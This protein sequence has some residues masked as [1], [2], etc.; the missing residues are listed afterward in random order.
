MEGAVMSKES[1]LPFTLEEHRQRLT[2]TR[3][4]VTRRG[5]DLMLVSIPENIF[6]LT[7]YD[8][9]GYF[10][11]QLIGVPRDG[12]PFMFMREI[13]ADHVLD[14]GIIGDVT[15]YSDRDD[16]VVVLRDTLAKR[17]FTS[18]AI[19]VEKDAWFFPP[20]RAERMQQAFAT[21]G[22]R[23]AAGVVEGQ[24][25]LK[26][27]A[28]IAYIRRA[29]QIA[30][31]GVRGGIAAVKA[32]VGEGEVAAAIYGALLR[33]GSEYAGPVYVMSGEQSALA[34]A[35]WSPRKLRQGDVVYIEVAGCVRRYHAAIRRTVTLGAAKPEVAK[36]HAACV[37]AQ[38]RMLP[39]LRP[40]VLSEEINRAHDEALAAA[41][42]S[43]YIRMRTAYSIGVSYPPGWGE[44]HI[45]DVRPGDRRPIQSR[46]SLHLGSQIIFRKQFGV[47]LSDTVIVREDGPEILTRLEQTLQEL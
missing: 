46:L 40:G 16:P 19:G 21:T 22:L 11:F 18:K 17:G 28:E 7:G 32:G 9:L 25:M 39:L 24:R 29:A 43:G 35:S 3:E 23:D 30:D 38:K 37:E 8:S 45:M 27:D 1:S 31:E 47:G 14:L 33:A 12:E 42:L 20:G 34:H 41:G 5:L 44:W 4:E 2:R 26:S 36:V 15:T 6:Y 13:E 10:A